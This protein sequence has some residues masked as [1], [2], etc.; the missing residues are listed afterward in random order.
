MSWKIRSKLSKASESEAPSPNS[1]S[2]K[3]SGRGS[4]EST[5][6]SDS[7]DPHRD[8]PT[9]ASPADNA[10]CSCNDCNDN[11]FGIASTLGEAPVQTPSGQQKDAA[12]DEI[13]EASQTTGPTEEK[14]NVQGQGSTAADPHVSSSVPPDDTEEQNCL[15][16]VMNR[17]D[18]FVKQI[19][20]LTGGLPYD[21]RLPRLHYIGRLSNALNWTLSRGPTSDRS[22]APSELCGNMLKQMHTE[23]TAFRDSDSALDAIACIDGALAKTSKI[24]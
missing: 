17:P 2:G 13:P 15:L 23:L 9:S 10:D 3:I 11:P 14:A 8:D 12:P 18:L 22:L 6:K 20:F 7:Q 24:Q 5:D 16:D 19:Q 1:E 4:Q 21:E